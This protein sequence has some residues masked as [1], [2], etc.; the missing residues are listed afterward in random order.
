MTQLLLFYFRKFKLKRRKRKKPNHG[1]FLE[2]KE[3]AGILVTKRLEHF[4]LH[5]KFLF[6]KVAIRNQVSRWGS[7]SKSGNLSFNYRIVFLS[8]NL[9]DY[10]IVHELCHIKEFNHSPKFWNLVSQTIP[11]CKKL[12]LE[13]KKT[14]IKT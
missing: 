12:R 10:I 1:R 13:L 7:C 3:K 9:A 8:P 14:R 2:H 11:N 6:K 5:Y 4:N